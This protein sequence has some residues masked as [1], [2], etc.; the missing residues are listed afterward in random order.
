MTLLS[1]NETNDFVRLTNQ[2]IAGIVRDLNSNTGISGVNERLLNLLS[3]KAIEEIIPLATIFKAQ[4]LEKHEGTIRC[5]RCEEE[6]S[7]VS[8]AKNSAVISY[9]SGNA[10]VRLVLLCDNCSVDL[11]KW[12]ES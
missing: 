4:Q 1:E 10:G 7:E 2:A 6:L 8:P 5:S 11:T 12:Y 9:G 3:R